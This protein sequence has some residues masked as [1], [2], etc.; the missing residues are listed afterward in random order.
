MNSTLR[1]VEKIFSP[2]FVPEGVGAKVKR[3]IGVPDL[4]RLDPFLMLDYFYVKLPAG[5][6]DHPHRG[7]ETVTYMQ[8]GSFF[9]EDFK[10]HKGRIDPGDLQ[11]MT[12]GKGIVHAEMPASD[13]E[14]SIGFQL[15]IN[16]EKDKKFCDP[17][18][19]EFKGETI[20]IVEKDGVEIKLISGEAFGT[21][22][23]IFARTPAFY[24]DITI[25]KNSKLSQNIPADWNAMCYVYEGE[26]YFGADQE[27]GIENN[28][29][30]LKKNNGD[31][32]EVTTKDK[33]LKFIL[34][35]GQPLNEKI[36]QY[37]PFVLENEED[38]YKTFEDYDLG[39]NGFEGAKK[40]K[41]EIRKLAK[42]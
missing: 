33:E 19:Q 21:K 12:A 22:G 38:L 3:I 26:G 27:K 24:M 41:S 25:K 20:P 39:K 28:A 1:K 42:K 6:P 32:L 34:L 9:H 35:A 2:K 11:W 13:T 7:F 8:K 4:P 31:T 14:E 16:L 17:A 15:W 30:V 5:F 29:I 23:P 10:G 18:Y 37:G 40:W 36:V